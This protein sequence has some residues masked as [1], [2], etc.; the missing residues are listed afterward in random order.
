MT[1]KVLIIQEKQYQYTFN[2]KKVKRRTIKISLYLKMFLHQT[3]YIH[4]E[5]EPNL[6][7]LCSQTANARSG[8]VLL[9]ASHGGGR[10]HAFLW[11]IHNRALLHHKALRFQHTQGTCSAFAVDLPMC[12]SQTHSG[13]VRINVYVHH[14][15]VLHFPVD[16][17]LQITFKSNEPD[18]D[19]VYRYYKWLLRLTFVCFLAYCLSHYPWV[20]L[21]LD[22]Q[23]KDFLSSAIYKRRRRQHK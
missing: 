23:S 9:V 10:G 12:T 8:D 22:I 21:T 2:R 4:H 18:T 20:N 5:V 3:L 17:A 13:F 7:V 1:R 14:D 19:K 16:L 11:E 6:F 15:C